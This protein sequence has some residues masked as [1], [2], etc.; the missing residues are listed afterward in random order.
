MPA[1]IESAY[2]VGQEYVAEDQLIEFVVLIVGENLMEQVNALDM[3]L[4]P[5]APGTVTRI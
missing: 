5:C 2:D 1:L 4:P 3:G